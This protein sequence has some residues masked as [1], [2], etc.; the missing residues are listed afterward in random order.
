MNQSDDDDNSD[1]NRFRVDTKIFRELGELLVGR[2]STAL[3]ELIKNAYDAD[4]TVCKVRGTDLEDPKKARITIEDDGIGMGETEFRNGFLTIGSRSKT[5]GDR[6]SPRFGRRYTGEKG[7]GRLAIHKLGE[8]IRIE[9]RRWDERPTPSDRPGSA[10]KGIIAK[11]DWRKIEAVETVDEVKD[12][13]SVKPIRSLPKDQFCGTNIRIEGL[14]KGWTPGLIRDFLN[15]ALSLTP[16]ETLTAPLPEVF[17]EALLLD[18]VA[19]RDGPRSAPDFAV[20]LL[21]GFEPQDQL[22]LARPESAGVALEIDCDP[23][24]GKIAFGLALSKEFLK[25]SKPAKS[26]LRVEAKKVLAAINKKTGE[27]FHEHCLS[28][29]KARVFERQNVG[30][31]SHAQGI[32]VYMEGFRVMPYGDSDDDW[33]GRKEAYLKRGAGN[34]FDYV[35]TLDILGGKAGETAVIR[36]APTLMGGIFL[37]S[38]GAPNLRMLVNREGFLPNDSFFLLK[39]I[40]VLGL[41]LATRFRYAHTKSPNRARDESSEQLSSIAKQQS[42]KSAA[43]APPPSA[44]LLKRHIDAVTE[45]A[46]KIRS[47]LGKNQVSEALDSVR[48]ASAALEAASSLVQ[49]SVDEQIMIRI[50][51]SL[52]T[53][54]A[55][56]NHEARNLLSE[57]EAVK[58]GVD[59]AREAADEKTTKRL[60]LVPLAKRADALLRNVEIQVQYLSNI[61]G[62]AGKRRRSRQ[63]VQD[64]FD[65]AFKVVQLASE[66]KDID[67]KK[68]IDAPIESPPMFPAELTMVFVNLLTNAVR[69]AREDGHILLHVGKDA[70]GGFVRLEN[71]GVAVDMA[72]SERWFRPFESST[73]TPDLQLGLGM[74][75]GLTITRSI[76]DEYGAKISFVKPA[77]GYATAIEIR[78]K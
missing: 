73:E 69:A 44:I 65:S 41:D 52:G 59:K 9:S 43:N 24:N 71:D 13:L 27:A 68:K 10:S 19:V 14:R 40:V 8:R 77:K 3:A 15:Q 23:K 18:K 64:R 67:V 47:D 16:S 78:F 70:I 12:G 37:T 61:V 38:A 31:P 75:L 30:W 6:R 58:S 2:D 25:Q 55:V 56:F 34:K 46:K 1:R 20:Q 48:Q 7:I 51:A 4:A 76:L 54:F 28:R 42:S 17:G 57:T 33:L 22:E 63:N 72:D 39:E 49:E 32:R 5:T 62:A 66:R 36:P 50:L 35:D 53:Q 45:T 11:L 21:G 26:V 74:G 29:F 60:G